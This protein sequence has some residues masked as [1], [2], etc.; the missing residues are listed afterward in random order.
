MST[1][2]IRR[3]T[4]TIP[5]EIRKKASLEDGT[6]ISIEYKPDDGVI[7]LKPDVSSTTEDYVTLSRKGK[8]M[9]EEA[10]KAEK[11]G[12]VIGPFSNIKDALK[13]LKEN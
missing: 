3:G 8:E 2:H 4:L 13:A 11:S 1:A 10:L 9:I 12:D 6:L 7:I 5:V